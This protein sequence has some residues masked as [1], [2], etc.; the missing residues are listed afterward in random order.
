MKRKFFNKVWFFE[1]FLAEES[2]TSTWGFQIEK[3]IFSGKSE[4]QK[5]EIFQTK[6]FGKVLVIDD[7]VQLGT[8]REFVYH[9]MLVHPGMMYIENPKKVLIVGGGDGG[10]LREVVKYPVKEIYLVEIDRMV[11][12]ISK[13]YLPEVSQ[14]AFFD[15]RLKIFYQDA[16]HFVKNFDH[17]FDFIVVDIT[18]PRGASFSLWEKKFLENIFKALREEGLASFQTGFL[19][20]KYGIKFRQKIKN[21]FNFF[22]IHKAFVEYFPFGEH[23]FSFASKKIDFHKFNFKKI[24]NKFEKLKIET[25][26]YSPKIHFSSLLSLN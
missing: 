19:S 24:K 18:D 10:V 5:I 11:V 25:K 7:L 13:K 4:F 21:T 12:E 3:E 26:Y 16:F 14:H 2:K 23:T 17:F 22:V 1:D 20:E 15:K 6:E 8:K 9:E